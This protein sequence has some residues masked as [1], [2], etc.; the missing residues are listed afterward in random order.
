VVRKLL[1]SPSE[2]KA[3]LM[4]SRTYIEFTVGII[5]A[6]LPTIKPL[7]NSFLDV[8]KA[9]ASGSRSKNASHHIKGSRSSTG[10][11]KTT[12]KSIA[13]DSF[14]TKG[15]P[16]P[17]RSNANEPYSVHVTGLADQEV[18][19]AERKG[20]DES[21]LPLRPTQ[22]ARPDSIGTTRVVSMV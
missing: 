19:E 7:F 20:S 1:T 13:M 3:N 14:V 22:A 6:S 12:D 11:Q 10:Y 17:P 21:N 4:S 18:W 15:T 9:L 5:A 16:S 2:A 8:A